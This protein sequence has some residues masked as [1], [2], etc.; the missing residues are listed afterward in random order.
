MS[1][2]GFEG[3]QDAIGRESSVTGTRGQ[4]DRSGTEIKR[5]EFN[6]SGYSDYGATDSDARSLASQE[7]TYDNRR[8]V[9]ETLA[10]SKPTTDDGHYY[11]HVG[12]ARVGHV[13]VGYGGGHRDCDSGYGS[14]SAYGGISGN[15]NDTGTGYGH[16]YN[17]RYKTAHDDYDEY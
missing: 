12:H 17:D 5:E 6:D 1:S 10:N 2:S 8:H 4:S 15:R 13:E 11:A 7:R 9:Q 3:V 16:S 14:A